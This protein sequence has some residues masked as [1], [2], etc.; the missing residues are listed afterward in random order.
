MKKVMLVDDEILIRE[1]IRDC[2]DWEKEGFIYCGDAPDGEVALPI[3]EQLQPDILITDILMP[4]MNGLEL[5]SIVRTKLPD[6]KIIILSGHGEF[7]YARTAM[8]M[9]VEEYCLKPVSA[10]EIIKLLHEVSLKIDRERESKASI[11]RLKQQHND[12]SIFTQFKLLNDLCSGFVTASEAIHL[13]SALHLN[14][15]A[16][17]YVVVMLDNRCSDQPGQTNLDCLPN[18]DALK[19]QRSRTETVW[20]IKGDALDQLQQ[21]LHGFKELQRQIAEELPTAALTLSV[22]IGSVQ[23]RLQNVH[24]SFLDAGEDMHW[25]R[26]SRQNRHALWE[27]SS[28]IID[29]S[30]FLDRGKF[31]DFLK[32]GDPSRLETFI[33]QYCDIL[34]TINWESSPIGYY[35]LNDLTLEV[36]RAAK[37][38]YSH[39]SDPAE[40]LR[41]FQQ[42]IGKIGTWQ[43]T[44]SYLT[45]L[46]E[47]FWLWRSR[48]Y[49]KYAGLLNKVKEYMHSNY[50][51]DSISLQDAAEHVNVS[52]SHL[53]KVFSQETGQTFIEYLTQIRI[54][55][56]MELLKTTSAKSYE[57]ADQV[58]YND[59]HYFSS[60]FKRVTGM[61]TTEFRKNGLSKGYITGLEGEEPHEVRTTEE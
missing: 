38:M 9:G 54:R 3:I 44:C 20:I 61:T 40:T 41:L 49:D 32:V 5:S 45:T 18:K 26:L 37:D 47:Q 43:E 46:T 15:I 11:E 50:N 8:R 33:E 28:E 52:P 21:E 30:I 39:L 22:G 4:F 48:M 10:A 36:F 31:I 58:G 56:A 13:S 2:I 23:D 27:T 1:T 6:V 14:I 42:Q 17:Y 16:R 19:F 12:Q 60:L 57:I 25:R 24:L 55:K 7:E 35:I 51:K 29:Q 34:K 53:S 59:A